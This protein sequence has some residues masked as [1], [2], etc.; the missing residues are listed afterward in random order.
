MPNN[1][2]KKT[3]HIHISD[4]ALSDECTLVRHHKPTLNHEVV[5]N[6]VLINEKSEEKSPFLY[7]DFS[8]K[9]II[10]SGNLSLLNPVGTISDSNLVA[11]D[12][13]IS[14]CDK[15]DNYIENNLITE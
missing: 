2:N 13:V 6:S 9:I 7:T 8:L 10:E 11:H 5:G 4:F 12:K 3:K 15:I 1:L 14:N